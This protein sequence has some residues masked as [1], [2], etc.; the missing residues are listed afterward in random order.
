MHSSWIN[1]IVIAGLL[2]FLALT[3]GCSP[4]QEV[5]ATESSEKLEEVRLAWAGGPRIWVLGQIDKS[6]DQALGVPVKWVEFASGAEVLSLFAANE[7]DIARFGNNP[8]IAGI[9][10]GLPIEIIGLEGLVA[11]SEKLMVKPEIKQL[12]D[13]AG[14][15]VAFPANSTA[16][17]ALEAAL[18]VQAIDKK[19]I[20]LLP[21]KPAEIVAAWNRG[22]IDAAYVW[23]P[24]SLELEKQGAHAI[25]QTIDLKQHGII[26]YNNFVVRKEFAQQ[27]PALV[28]AFL[29]NYQAKVDE[30]QNAPEEAISKLA[31]HLS[32]PAEQVRASLSGI[33]YIPL[34]QQAT[35][36]YLGSINHDKNSGIAQSA[37]DIA[38]FLIRTGEI[39]VQ[40]KPESYADFINN[41]YLID[42]VSV[43]EP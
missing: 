32:L 22:D 18:E 42:A 40:D 20:R 8:A 31:R 12:N 29:R 17:F 9:S 28:S 1:R 24:F 6:F 2:S 10:R 43:Q 11:T 27:H 36:V 15:T 4:E 13:L 35:K 16:Q 37:L 19:S 5:T 30:Y 7:I 33:E 39:R 34:E 14:K 26:V 38:D 23:A 25:Y 21:L 3:Q 41:Q